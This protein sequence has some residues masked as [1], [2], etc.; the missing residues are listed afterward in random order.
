[1]DAAGV[2]PPRRRASRRLL[3]L[4]L[5]G[6]GVAS[7]SAYTVPL[8]AAPRA[9]A[10]AARSPPPACC[11][12]INCKLVD[13]CKVYHWVETMHEQPHLT[14]EPDFDPSKPEVQVFIRNEEEATPLYEEEAE[15]ERAA[16]APTMS[17]AAPE[18]P[19]PP[20]PA[21]GRP[22]LTTEFDVFGCA[23][24]VEDDGRWIRLM[25]DAEYIP[26]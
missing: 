15:D 21:D 24:F 10:A 17:Q 13:R 1:M 11:I 6:W 18:P 5:A 20:P 7:S 8:G 9:P 14:M 23:S 4:A 26:T 25:P 12:C 3:R 22:V 16:A 19:P 2:H